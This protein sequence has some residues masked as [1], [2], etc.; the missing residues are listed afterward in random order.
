MLFGRSNVNLPPPAVQ[1]M[2]SALPENLELTTW[3]MLDDGSA[4]LRLT[5]VYMVGEHPTLSRPATVD[6]CKL[7]GAKLCARLAD[8]IE[9][10]AAGDVRRDS[11]QRLQWKVKGEPE[12]TS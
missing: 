4:L 1:P 12:S 10:N 7:F 8:F 2:S 6:I 11:V 9:M 3:Q 5:H